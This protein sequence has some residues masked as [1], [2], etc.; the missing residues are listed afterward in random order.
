MCG[1]A[2]IFGLQD[3][4]TVEQMVKELYH[5]GPDESHQV[6]GKSFSL[7]A[8]RLSILDLNN[9]RQPL[10]N[11]NE[12]IW[13]AQ[14]GEIYN[15]PSLK[16]KLLE[17]GHKLRTGCDTEILP[18]LYEEY[19]EN[20]VDHLD[21]MFA[22]A[23][24]DRETDS[25][26]LSR[27]RMGKKPLFYCLS[28][29]VL[30]FASEIKSILKIPNFKREINLNGL[31]HFLSLKHIPAPLTIFKNIFSLPP[32][33]KLTYKVGRDILVKQYWQPDFTPDLE[34]QKMSES[35]LEEKLLILLKTGVEKRLLSD[36]PVGFFLSGG[37][38]SSLT[39]AIA[40][41]ICGSKIKTFSL[42]YKNSISGS[43]KEQDI[44]WARWLSKKLNTEHH[45]E[46]IDV[47]D[48]PLQL[49]EM[50]KAF[51]EPF[52]GTLSTFYL[53]EKISKHVKVALS[54]DGADELFGS[55]LSHRLAFPLSSLGEPSE[56]LLNELVMLSN[57]TIS[58]VKQLTGLQ[59]W[60]WRSKLFVR[61]E[62]DKYE[63]YSNEY[64]EKMRHF[65]TTDYLKDKFQGLTSQDP[66]NRILEVEYKSI[67]PDQVLAYVDRLSMAHSLEVR[68]A[69]LDTQL[70]EFVT[71]LPGKYK[72]NNGVNKYLL[73]KVARK[74]LPED[75]VYRPKEGFVLPINDWI[76]ADLEEYVKDTLSPARLREHGIFDVEVVDRLVRL[77]Y[78]GHPDY[79]DINKVFTLLVFQI[80]WKIYMVGL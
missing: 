36:V 11:E 80:W 61:G 60:E 10:S 39:T 33:H 9:G 31:H 42:G 51:D 50:I 43:G 15:Y 2:G 7:G 20:F 52:A 34:S 45:E 76:S 29:G 12:R 64:K 6:V 55:Y 53:A 54:G 38:D 22:I 14:N 35:Q 49:E 41:E 17:R 58:E 56:E 47:L 30:Y 67:F 78:E 72:I 37:V 73:K 79:R 75:M 21:G 69:F 59:D 66:L 40:A 27:D 32:G 1:I 24:W 8:A 70:I 16:K 77:V 65:S 13:A 71:K 4:L 23:I 44:Y 46:I 48:F 74:Y 3:S 57:F 18:Y 68:S 25:G 19:G 63:L 28:E 62:Q 26:I 5:R